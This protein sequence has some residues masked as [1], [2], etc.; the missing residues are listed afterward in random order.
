MPMHCHQRKAF[1]ALLR[2]RAA[3]SMLQN[4]SS[5][6][7]S[8]RQVRSLGSCGSAAAGL[9][10][11]LHIATRGRYAVME[12]STLNNHQLHDFA[13]FHAAAAALA[14]GCRRV[15][16]VGR[17]TRLIVDGRDGTGQLAAAA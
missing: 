6:A 17:Q 9:V 14:N 12:L 16:V 13:R 7:W 5:A 10:A 8:S 4:H 3:S 11:S 1:A 2:Y 15:E